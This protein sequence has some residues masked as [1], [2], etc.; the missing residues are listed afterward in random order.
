[1]ISSAAK[2]NSFQNIL[3]TSASLAKAKFRLRMEGSYL[4]IFWYLLK[5]LTL[6]LLILFIKAA[7]FS[8]VVIPYYPLYLFMGITAVNFFR[9]VLS[10][11]INAIS[12]SA[13]H[14][15]SINNVAPEVLVL[16]KVFLA[17]YSHVFE[18]A[19]IAV[20]MLVLNISLVGLLFYPLIFACFVVMV[21]GIAFIFAT[22]GV[23][24]N[25]FSN[26]WAI[27]A[28]LL[29]FATPTF[30]AIVPG[31]S[32]YIANLFNPLFYFLDISRSA[33]IYSSWPP[34]GMIAVLVVG[35]GFFL[36]IGLAIFKRYKHKF[37]ELV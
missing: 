7:A 18:F 28:Q 16:S 8:Q 31:S 10:D 19:L 35:S 17:V 14:I 26:I 30:Y 1:M 4:G 12:A 37:S 23:Y 24:I 5:P 13:D 22:I 36:T 33:V 32:V 11:S 3:R 27:A 15:K 20:L 21:A 2:S 9:T 6:F 25:D 34:L 29:F